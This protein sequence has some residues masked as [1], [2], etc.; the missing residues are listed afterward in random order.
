MKWSTYC[1]VF[2]ESRQISNKFNEKSMKLINYMRNTKVHL[3]KIHSSIRLMA[4]ILKHVK[5]NDVNNLYK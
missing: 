1:E 4:L 3:I 5:V 2:T